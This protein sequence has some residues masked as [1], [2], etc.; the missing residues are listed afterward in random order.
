MPHAEEERVVQQADEEHEEGAEDNEEDLI[1]AF[2]ALD[3]D[4]WA[5]HV[6]AGFQQG[7]RQ[8][9]P[10]TLLTGRALVEHIGSDDTRLLA[11]LTAGGLQRSTRLAHAGALRLA[12]LLPVALGHLP[13]GRALVLFLSRLQRERKWKYTTLAKNMA[14]LQGALRILPLYRNAEGVRLADD[15]EWA[16]ASAAAQRRSKVER[17]RVPQAASFEGMR[18]AIGGTPSLPLRAIL[19]FAWSAA[20]RIGDVLRLRKADVAI[21]GKRLQITWRLTKTVAARGPYTVTVEPPADWLTAIGRWTTSR[22]TWLFPKEITTRDVLMALRN[23]DA[24][25]ECRSIRRGALQ[26][27]AAAGVAE[28]ILMMISG[29]TCRQTLLR[30]LAWGAGG[31]LRNEQMTTASKNMFRSVTAAAQG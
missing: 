4:D 22:H 25:L 29:H 20:A 8:A 2:G 16:L 11:E 10:L 1:D 21:L 7:Q 6:Q 24:N 14:T 3:R 13:A 26:T 9:R 18:R 30:Y 23:V 12:T 31:L 27:L 17:A 28:D 15:P 5:A 19:M